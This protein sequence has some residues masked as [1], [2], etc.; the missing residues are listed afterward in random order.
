MS[1]DDEPV[2]DFPARR[3]VIKC[4]A[5]PTP[6]EPS[7]GERSTASAEG[8]EE[9]E[10]R[11]QAEAGVGLQGELRH[12]QEVTLSPAG[13]SAVPDSGHAYAGGATTP[14]GWLLRLGARGRQPDASL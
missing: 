4:R 10:V 14:S 13:A 1:R 7:H 12:D 5:I 11:R 9:A 6:E 8:K 2:G 3:A